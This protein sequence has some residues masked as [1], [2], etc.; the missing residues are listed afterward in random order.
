MTINAPEGS[1]GPDFGVI[2]GIFTDGMSEE[3][4]YIVLR[5][6]ESLPNT[7]GGSDIDIWV[8]GD[9]RNVFLENAYKAIIGE[10][11]CVIGTADTVGFRK[12]VAFGSGRNGGDWWGITLDLFF[13]VNYA[14]VADLVNGDALAARADKHNGINVL[15]KGEAAI[16]GVLKEVLHNLRVPER[17]LIEARKSVLHNWDQQLQ[18]FAPIGNRALDILKDICQA[19]LKDSRQ[20][21]LARRLRRFVLLHAFYQNPFRYLRGRLAFLWSRV[22]RVIDPPGIIIAILGTD[23]SG[24]STIISAIEPVLDAATHGA[25]TVKHLR[26]GWLPPLARLKGIKPHGQGPVTDPHGARPSSSLVSLF[27]LAYLL[28]D[29]LVGYWIKVRPRIARSPAV[30]LFDRYA[31]D[32]EMDPRRFRI[33]LPRRWLRLAGRLAPKPDLIFC[34]DGDP[35]EI[36]SRKGELPLE[37]VRRQVEWIR[38]FAGRNSNA[39]LIST[40]GSVEE[41]RDQVLTALRDYCLARNPLDEPSG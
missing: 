14:G 30:V 1:T 18:L 20:V 19:D 23:G 21:Q 37:E 34:L 40:R 3:G 16:L 24:K 5:N 27:R 8:F 33:R 38:D 7:A 39:V 17:Y 15:S 12:L 2:N 13:R 35:E 36:A 4:A 29:Y 22:S 11:G 6:Y 9:H 41:T 32:L 26:P 10:G 25:F 31:F 28:T